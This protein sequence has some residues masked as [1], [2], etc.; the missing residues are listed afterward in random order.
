[1]PP[2]Q[3][4]NRSEIDNLQSAI[5]INGHQNKM[6]SEYELSRE[7]RIRENRERM[8][9]L[10]ILDISL[11]LK[12][13]PNPPPSRRTPSN[14][15]KS[16]ISLNPSGPS[17]RSSRLQNVA[18]I[19]YS[20]VPVKGEKLEK[21]NRIVLREGSQPE[22]Y[23][24]EHEKLLGNTEKTWELF[25]DGVGKDGK[26]IYDS[27]QGKTCHQCRQKT[28]G[29]RTRCCE[30]NIVQ[31]QFCGDCLYMRYGEHVLEALADPTWKC[32]PCRGIC[33]CSIC[34]NAKGWEPTG[35]LYRKVLQL[36]YK[37]VA[38][39][40]IQTRCSDTVEKTDDTCNLVSDTDVEKID[41]ASNLVS[42]TDV[43]KIDD[44]SNLVSD[45]DVEKIDD[46]SNPVLDTDVE[47]NGDASN[48]VS[49]KR[50]LP[51][52]DEVNENKLGPMQS[53]AEAEADGDKVLAK[54]SLIFPDEQDK[55]EKSEGSNTVKLLASSTKP[56]PDSIAGRLR[57]RVKKP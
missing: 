45:T 39:Y 24:E 34:R 50:S 57:S 10:G 43:E 30:C 29:Y 25:V 55:V 41:D 53:L 35:N 47:K 16:P 48:P 7:E 40:L 22:I 54:R 32:P 42:D 28:L 15:P 51:F 8:G 46:A 4:R 2:L 31:G 38:H 33:N 11:S 19:S 21:S 36:G 1:M 27:V 52:S 20:E 56:T 26:R 3:K 14:N 6:M 44:A 49:V 13:K 9:K 23:T 12:L 37:S 18:P 17:R 5:T